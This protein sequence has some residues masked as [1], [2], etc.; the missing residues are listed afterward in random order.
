MTASQSPRLA[1]E[2][3]AKRQPFE[4]KSRPIDRLLRIAEVSEM[5]GLG[6]TTIYKLMKAS[7]SPFP[8]AIKLGSA[9]ARWRESEVMLWMET[10]PRWAGASQ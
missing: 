2:P 10:L 5:T 4:G 1:C 9:C 3:R 8:Q 6:K 7:E